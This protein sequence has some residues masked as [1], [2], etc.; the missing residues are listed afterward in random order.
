L[1]I[2]GPV[3]L[4]GTM[5]KGS[6]NTDNTSDYATAYLYEQIQEIRRRDPNAEIDIDIKGHSRGGVAAAKCM[7]NMKALYGDD[8]RI[9]AGLLQLDPVAGGFSFSQ[10]PIEQSYDSRSNTAANPA[11]VSA[12]Q[13]NEDYQKNRPDN[14]QH[15][16]TTNDF[17]DHTVVYS[18]KSG[19][20]SGPVE[21]AMFDPQE[22]YGASRVILVDGGMARL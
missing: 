4:G 21:K 7:A 8:S 11:L 3:A 16:R 1:Y 12:I 22:V 18:L 2:G 6:N 15:T 10:S 5:D 17:V 9:T 19:D 20:V 13:N 14:R